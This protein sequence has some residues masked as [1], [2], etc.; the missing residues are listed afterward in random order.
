PFEVVLGGQALEPVRRLG[1]G[2]GLAAPGG[3][4][5]MDEDALLPMRRTRRRVSVDHALL[6]VDIHP[7]E[8]AADRL[9]ELPAAFLV[10]VEN[11]HPGART[12]Q[13]LRGG[14]PQSRGAA[15]DDRAGVRIDLHA[16]SPAV[17]AMLEESEG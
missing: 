5:A 8:D 4:R 2:E 3:H 16:L 1:E 14:A 11:G 7:A 12:G 17:S 9:R 15:G 13:R 10:D 6:V